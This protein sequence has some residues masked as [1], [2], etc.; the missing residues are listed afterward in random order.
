MALDA[1]TSSDA[2]RFCHEGLRAI[3][4][5]VFMGGRATLACVSQAKHMP[6]QSLSAIPGLRLYGPPAPVSAD[7]TQ[8]SC[9]CALDHF[10]P[11]EASAGPRAALVAFN[12][13]PLC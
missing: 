9:A 4:G 1:K 6:C 10:G 5:T 11:C 12:D 2:A 13:T 8:P 3:L 7:G